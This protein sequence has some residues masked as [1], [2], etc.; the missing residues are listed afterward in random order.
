MSNN[1]IKSRLLKSIN[2]LDKTIEETR[3]ILDEIEKKISKINKINANNG[4][5]K[6]GDSSVN[7]S[8]QKIAVEWILQSAKIIKLNCTAI[9]QSDI[10]SKIIDLNN[11]VKNVKNAYE[12]A[13]GLLKLNELDLLI[14][15]L[16]STAELQV[17]TL[18]FYNKFVNRLCTVTP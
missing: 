7:K 16:V 11:N 10:N 4:Q 13:K 9:Q 8:G 14:G 12:N 1:N 2:V 17:K 3:T 15:S 5:A 18:L 6:G